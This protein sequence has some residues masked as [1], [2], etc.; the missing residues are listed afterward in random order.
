VDRL[1]S[2]PLRESAIGS[3]VEE[4]RIWDPGAGCRLAS[5]TVDA[6]A[7]QQRTEQCFTLWQ[8]W[9]P[10]SAQRW[11]KETDFPDEI[12]QRWLSEKPTVWE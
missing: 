1:P 9:D 7:R 3:Y 4:V 12:K 5:K 2:G 11:L 10:D 8:A 6:V